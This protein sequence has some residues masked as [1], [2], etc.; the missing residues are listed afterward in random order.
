MLEYWSIGVLECWRI[1][2]L[3][4]DFYMDNTNLKHR[5]AA[6]SK[7]LMINGERKNSMK[8]SSSIFIGFAAFIVISLEFSAFAEPLPTAIQCYRDSTQSKDIDAYMT[9]FADDPTIIDVSRT[10]EGKKTIRE[11]AL[12]EVIPNGDSFKHQEI[13]ERESNYAKTLVKWMV[14]KAHYFYW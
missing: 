7:N 1:G 5:S 4:L 3:D 6:M 8:N 13:L 9:C 11:W 12:R 10:L 14:W 2:V